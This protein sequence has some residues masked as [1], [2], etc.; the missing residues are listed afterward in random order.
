MDIL[1]MASELTDLKSNIKKL[2]HVI[3]QLTKHV[4][5]EN[6]YTYNKQ[7]Q[8]LLSVYS[9]LC[10]STVD[11]FKQNRIKFFS[12]ILHQP[13][14][15]WK[16][17]PYAFP[18]S[19]M[20][21]FDDSGMTWIP[22]AGS[23]VLVLFEAGVRR[24]PFYIGTTWSRTRG[25]DTNKNGTSFNFP[26]PE[27]DEIYQGKRDGYL[28]GKQNT[29]DLP[30]W[31]T[32]NYNAYDID[33]L[34]EV[35]LNPNEQKRIT[36]P[37]IYGF[38]TPEKH[39]LKM[40]DGDPKCNRRWKRME[41]LS[42]NGNW[43]IFKDDVF[44]YAGQWT[45]PACK[46]G[47]P[48]DTSCVMGL[49]NPKSKTDELVAGIFNKPIEKILEFL[50]NQNNVDILP[51]NPNNVPPDE[52]YPGQSFPHFKQSCDPSE[53][54]NPYAG[55]VQSALD[56]G[57]KESPKEM[58]VPGNQTTK[59]THKVGTNPF[60]KNE[61]ECR[62]YKGPGNPQN[63]RADLPQTGVQILSISGHTL[64][65]DDS[66][67]FPQ[68]VTDWH[69]S[70]QNFDYG[71]TDTYLGRSYMKSS[72]GHLIEMN[73]LEKTSRVR[74]KENGI[75]LKSGLGNVIKLC[76]DTKNQQGFANENTGIYMESTSRH[77][78]FMCDDGNVNP[79]D[80]R[81]ENFNNDNLATNAYIRM[82]SGYGLEFTMADVAS[83]RKTQNQ[84]IQIFCPQTDNTEKGPHFMQFLETPKGPG[85]IVLRAGG[86]Y[87]EF[88]VD[89]SY[90]VVGYN[91]DPNDS[92]KSIP[93]GGNKVTFASGD[94]YTIA[95]LKSNVVVSE[96]FEYHWAKKQ[97]YYLAGED[98]PILDD[99]GNDT[100]EKGPGVFPVVVFVPTIDP[101]T[102]KING[103]FLRISDRIYSSVSPEGG[104]VTRGNLLG[105]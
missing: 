105:G 37:N 22:P 86:N 59:D 87:L 103:G 30:P 66:V 7:D 13:S 92:K 17:L 29:Q 28:L 19:S 62:P 24:T 74:G 16:S 35:A 42:G 57:L 73:D 104:F 49:E 68:G 9:C 23:T 2:G 48:A 41:L 32:E 33:S 45:H 70:L 84:Y 65:M 82:R 12:P 78:F 26:V 51:Y 46:A 101:K 47:T 5:T 76:D 44:H 90:E 20:G 39:M 99:Q 102:K 11:Y 50:V 6:S 8:S 18:I 81:K 67:E 80:I 63:N 38:K 52:I 31:N 25:D 75:L 100:G 14:T 21:G 97:G 61:N 55:Y 36:Y 72:S 3:K 58:Y 85:Q 10:V 91:T 96:Q 94:I 56:A 69:R 15:N 77:T 64:V 40:V 89:D 54:S 4:N 34:L 79:K 95:E 53:S 27:F 43:M 93:T 60:F 98:Y 71:C 1:K 88:T 83:Q